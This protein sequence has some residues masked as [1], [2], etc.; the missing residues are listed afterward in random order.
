MPC[1]GF[2]T[3]KTLHQWLQRDLQVIGFKF[4]DMV[5]ENLFSHYYFWIDHI[6]RVFKQV[7]SG[8]YL[9]GAFGWRWMYKL[10]FR[11]ICLNFQKRPN[12]WYNG[13]INGLFDHLRWQWNIDLL[14]ISTRRWEHCRGNKKISWIW[15][16]NILDYFSLCSCW[17]KKSKESQKSL[18][19]KF[20][21]LWR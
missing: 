3:L 6:T 12:S 14:K 1:L 17:K 2:I 19:D 21:R 20:C 18:F 8:W 4:L 13:Q 11:T 5:A 15:K 10:T 7:P 9:N 16:M